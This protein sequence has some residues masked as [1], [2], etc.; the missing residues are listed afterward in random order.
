MNEYSIL[1]VDDKTENFD[2]IEVFLQNI[3]YT[4]HYAS[5]G[6][7]AIDSLDKF[8]PDL[9]LLDVMM[10]EI[11]GIEVCKQIKVSPRWQAVPIIMVT[12][13]SSTDDLA[14]CLKAGADDFIS[15]PVNGVELRARVHSMLRIKKQHDRIESLSKLQRNSINS[16]KDSLSDLNS[17]LAIGF[18]KESTSP[19][20]NVLD[21]IQLL[22]KDIDEMPLSTIKETLVSINHSAIQLDRFHQSFLF[23]RQLSPSLPESE[24][25]ESCSTRT[26]IEQ[27]IIKQVE[28]SQQLPKLTFD[29]EDVELAVVPKYLQ[30]IVIELIDYILKLSESS[31]SINIYGHA[32]NDEFHFC[33]D[34]RG[35][36]SRGIPLT[37]FS[38]SIKFNP[39]SNTDHE[40]N[41]G[42]KITKKIIE[43]HDGLFLISNTIPTEA[44]IYIIL[45]LLIKTTHKHQES[46][47]I[48]V[49]TG[50]SISDE[51]QAIL[52]CH[53]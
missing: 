36:I 41:T 2:V 45:P 14:R 7:K 38:A 32:I 27:I 18:P 5:S 50:E 52:H 4:L 3:N 29:I 53:C 31:N 19:L 44:T 49:D 37:E 30:S 47:A 51:V 13:L 24:K 39:V 26:S 8:D 28:K 46:V 21:K 11:D 9:I 35:G 42:L 6:K 1:V 40:L 17:D 10:P 33:I 22:L 48:G 15:K 20:H 43:I 25:Q 16:L 23:T 34:N 12:S